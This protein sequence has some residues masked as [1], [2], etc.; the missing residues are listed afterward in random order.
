MQIEQLEER[1]AAARASNNQAAVAQLQPAVVKLQGQV[2]GQTFA[3][4]GT[5]P[6]LPFARPEI[7]SVFLNIAS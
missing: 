2:Q 6:P 3:G 4:L 1:I 7:P 5:S